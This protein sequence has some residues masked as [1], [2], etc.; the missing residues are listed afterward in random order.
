MTPVLRPVLRPVL[1]S[2][3]PYTMAGKAKMELMELEKPYVKR[4]EQPGEGGIKY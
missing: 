1:S 2:L 3:Y 4:L